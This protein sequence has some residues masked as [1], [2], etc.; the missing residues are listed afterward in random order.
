VP[1]Q[2]TK[3]QISFSYSDGYGREIQ[4]KIQAEPRPLVEGGPTVSLR[5]IGSG[6]TVFNNKGEPIRQYEP[7]FD[8]THDFRFAEKV[9]VSP[10][11]FYDPIERVVATLHPN[12]SFE[13]VV[14]DPWR[15]ITYD[16]N[17]TVTFDPKTDPDAGEF[18][19]RL[20]DADYL[21][22]WYQQ[23]SNGAKGPAEQEAAV[24]PAAHADTP[25]VA[26]F[27]TLGRSFLTIADNGKDAA[28][29]AQKYR[30]RTD[31]DIEGNQRAVVDAKDRVVMRYDYDMLGTRIHQASMEA[32]E[33]WMLNEVTGKP[34]RAW[35]SRGFTRRM[36]YDALRRPTACSSAAPISPK[37]RP[38]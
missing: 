35:D 1:N 9:G 2:A 24:K 11:L 25:T 33:H 4:K 6:W 14:F 15:Q 5:W 29:N 32:G 38:K 16:V 3:F 23:R 36:T 28:G 30:T 19:T 7:F 31:L 8:D 17:D 34:I 27:D 10:I 21:P 26:Y 37:F 12:H 20:P 22:T 18:F 13:K